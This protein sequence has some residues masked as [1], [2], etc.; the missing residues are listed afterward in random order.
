MLTG[1]CVSSL[2]LFRFTLGV[3][4]EQIHGLI[5]IQPN[6]RKHRIKTSAHG[7]SKKPPHINQK[8]YYL[9]YCDVHFILMLHVFLLI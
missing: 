2:R 1:E 8:H 7:D 3:G 9:Y 4:H 6:I 5:D